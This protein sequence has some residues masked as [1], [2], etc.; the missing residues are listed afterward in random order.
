MSSLVRR[1]TIRKMKRVGYT[2][3]K[4]ILGVAPF[5]GEPKLIEVRKGGEITDPDDNPIGRRWPVR[6]PA[7]ISA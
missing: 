3:E 2:R 6:M 5:N 7:R 1:I 4:W